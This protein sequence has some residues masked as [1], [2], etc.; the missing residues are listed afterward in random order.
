MGMQKAA[1]V[2]TVLF[3]FAVIQVWALPTDS[4]KT[5]DSLKK[6]EP[7]VS[8]EKWKAMQSAME[9]SSP[10][11]AATKNAEYKTMGSKSIMLLTFKIMLYLAILCVILYVVLKAFRKKM[12]GQGSSGRKGRH[13]EVVESTPI[14]TQ[15]HLTLVRVGG[16]LLVIGVADSSISLLTEIVDKEEVKRMITESD[17]SATQ[18]AGSFSETVDSFL[19]R[20]R[21]EGRGTPLSQYS[22][23]QDQG[24]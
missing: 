22:R 7:V 12:Q 15:K 4:T 13:L 11:A 24:E 8:A 5:V 1:K 19:A 21:K 18:F 23:S 17:N 20:F 3:L 16:R 10:A 9:N 6:S 2:F 14:G